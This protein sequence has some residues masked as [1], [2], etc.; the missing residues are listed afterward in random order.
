MQNTLFAQTKR[1]HEYQNIMALQA[2]AYLLVIL[3]SSGSIAITLY[4]RSVIDTII[5]DNQGNLGVY[6]NTSLPVDSL[7]IPFENTDSGLVAYRISL[8]QALLET[9]SVMSVN[10][11]TFDQE[12]LV[13]TDNVTTVQNEAN[14]LQEEGVYL[15]M[16]ELIYV[17]Q[18]DYT[19]ELTMKDNG[20]TFLFVSG[21]QNTTIVIPLLNGFTVRIATEDGLTG[22]IAYNNV[23]LDGGGVFGGYIRDHVNSIGQASPSESVIR[24]P[25]TASS[26]GDWIELQ[27]ISSNVVQAH[28]ET[29]LLDAGILFSSLC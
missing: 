14:S 27:V 3:V 16:D 15:T 4:N 24:V 17:N 13:E 21:V 19:M 29:T 11:T 8:L 20:H 18:S 2:I 25:C 23:I 7:W 1:L 26:F 22:G 10:V 6:L 9:F 5:T 28:G 12:L